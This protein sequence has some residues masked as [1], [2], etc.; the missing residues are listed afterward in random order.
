MKLG[1]I[2][3]SKSPEHEVSVVSGSSVIKNL[4]KKK[5]DI[6]PIYID[7]ENEW[8]EVLD[9]PKK[10]EIMKIGEL[11]TNI[12]SINNVFKYLKNMDCILPVMH[13]AYGEDGAIQGL[14][15]MLDIPC[16]GC[17]IL[18]SSVCMDKVVTKKILKSAGILVTP[19]IYIEYDGADFFNVLD[20]YNM[21]K[22]TVVDIDNLIKK[23]FGYPVYVKPANSGS[24][25]GISKAG[26]A[27]ELN[28][29][30]YEAK[31][32][33]SKILIEKAI[34]A[35][36][37]ECAVL[38]DL[39]SIPGEVL[40]ATEFYSF[41]AKYKNSKSKTAI[42][43]EISD[44]LIQEVRNIAKRA[45]KAINGKGL[46]RIDFFIEKDTNKIYLNEINT[47]PGFT[48]ISMY[49]KMIE[50]MG[51]SYSELLDKLI[52]NAMK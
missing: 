15:K 4:N 36:E 12:K 16:V 1:I 33:D 7:K 24:S 13:G 25:I 11:P 9:D 43:A 26:N 46:S 41:D 48:E 49:P 3:G 31:K 45:F 38:D 23:G 22:I 5:Y 40:S 18:A 2:F 37:I 21:Q 52:E 27:D 14:L 8:Y 50:N 19:D 47:M 42:P 10:Q 34:V 51:I 17:G 20:D 32:Y 6:Y 35:R 44:E 29:A 39:V 28:V 30:L